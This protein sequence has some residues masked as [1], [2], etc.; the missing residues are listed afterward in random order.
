ME[1]LLF[2][3]WLFQ[4]TY[5]IFSVI[6]FL[7][8]MAYQTSWLILSQNYLCKR[9]LVVPI[10]WRDKIH[11]TQGYLSESER[12]SATGVRTPVTDCNF[13]VHHFSHCATGDSL[14][15]ELLWYNV[16]RSYRW[17]TIYKAFALSHSMFGWKEIT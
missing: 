9:I 12:N 10:A 3:A 5:P 6:F 8:Q 17:P 7:Y 15:C 11:I 14:L 16:C 1:L 13:V 4:E 2:G